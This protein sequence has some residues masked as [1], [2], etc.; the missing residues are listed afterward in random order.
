MA[1]RS[2]VRKS[3]AF[4]VL[5]VGGRKVL[6]VVA[7]EAGAA[8]VAISL[9]TLMGETTFADRRCGGASSRPRRLASSAS[10]WGRAASIF[11][12][13]ATA[14]GN[15][16]GRSSAAGELSR[17]P[18]PPRAT[19]VPPRAV[20]TAKVPVRGRAAVSATRRRSRSSDGC[21][22]E[23][24]TIARLD[25][26]VLSTSNRAAPSGGWHGAAG[27]VRR[28]E[29]RRGAAGV[30]RLARFGWARLGEVGSGAAWPWQARLPG[31]HRGWSSDNSLDL[32][33]PSVRSNKSA[34]FCCFSRAAFNVHSR[35]ASCSNGSGSVGG[36][37]NIAPSRRK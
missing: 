7:D 1:G 2:E 28:G 15:R 16:R 19:S 37:I 32:T 9:D 14:G 23:A 21:G 26:C 25:K 4:G 13:S 24:S 5:S 10:P 33:V 20:K 31:K 34:R 6:R 11:S 12:S 8:A 35:T 27:R 17:L 3:P 18:T 29:A 22:G 36:G 30:A